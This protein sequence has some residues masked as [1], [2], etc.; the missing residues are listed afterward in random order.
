M[1]MSSTTANVLHVPEGHC[2]NLKTSQTFMTATRFLESLLAKD[3]YAVSRDE[4]QKLSQMVKTDSDVFKARIV[5]LEEKQAMSDAEIARQEMEIQEHEKLKK[6]G[7]A[8]KLLQSFTSL[9]QNWSNAEQ[10]VERLRAQHP[11]FNFEKLAEKERN[12]KEIEHLVGKFENA[13]SNVLARSSKPPTS[14]YLEALTKVFPE[15]VLQY[16]FGPDIRRGLGQMSAH[17][18]NTEMGLSMF[19]RSIL[20][21]VVHQEVFNASFEPLLEGYNTILENYREKIRKQ[22]K[23]CS[24]NSFIPQLT[25]SQRVSTR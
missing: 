17:L 23:V 15:S 24:G 25:L 5:E 10:E 4:L 22:R 6:P 8:E 16:M 3:K 18:C 1:Q 11:F 21:A 2:G 12:S 9:Q 7:H 19:T 20:A 13:L 14:H